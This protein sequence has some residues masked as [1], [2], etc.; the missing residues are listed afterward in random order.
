ME[1]RFINLIN[2]L[3]FHGICKLFSIP[4]VFGDVWYNIEIRISENRNL[5]R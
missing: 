3:K 1:R 4:N 2:K 5:N